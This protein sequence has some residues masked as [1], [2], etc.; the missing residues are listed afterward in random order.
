MPL[1]ASLSAIR[2]N[3]DRGSGSRNN[4]TVIDSERDIQNFDP[5][6]RLMQRLGM[7]V[8]DDTILRQLKRDATL[9]HRNTD[10]RVVGIDDWSWRRATSYGGPS[11]SISSAARLSTF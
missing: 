10:I 6:E 11:W 8:S 2:A 1:S 7:P 3:G 5:W 9:A 4:P